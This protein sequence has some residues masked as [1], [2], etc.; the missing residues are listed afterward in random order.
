MTIRWKGTVLAVAL[1]A[2]A[3]GCGG[4]GGGGGGET[5]EPDGGGGSGPLLVDAGGGAGGAQPGGT[6]GSGGDGGAGGTGGAGGQTGGAPT[7]DMGIRFAC[8]DGVDNDDDGLIDLTDPGCTGPEDDD[9]ADTS[10]AAQCS[11]GLDNDADGLP[12]LAD[13]DCSSE[14]DPSEQGDN[15]DTP[16]SNDLDDDGDG[17]VDFPNDPGCRAAGDGDEADGEPAPACANAA[18]DD[19]DGRID[20]PEDPGCQGRGDMNEADPPVAPVCSNGMDDDADGLTDYPADPGCAAAADADESGACGAGHD[21]IDLNAALAADGHY[22]GALEGGSADF[23]GSCG[24]GAGPERIFEYRLPERVGALIFRTDHPETDKP[25]VVY[26][27]S[28]CLDPLDLVCNRGAEANPGTVARLERPEPGL[29]YVVV[30]TSSAALGPGAFRLT[31]ETIPADACDNAR[32]D[33]GDGRIDLADPGC[34]AAD[35]LDEADPLE[36][37]ACANGL[38]DDMDGQTDYPND[39]D[40]AA[41]GTPLEGPLCNPAVNLVEVAAPGGQYNAVLG[42]GDSTTDSRCGPG[43]GIETVFAVSVLEASR[44]SIRA[45]DP[46]EG[47]FQVSVRESCDA[48]ESELDCDLG[49]FGSALSFAYETD[50]AQT[51]YVVVEANQ[52]GFVGPSGQVDVTIEVESLITECND[53]ADNDADGRIDLEDLGCERGSDDSEADP[54]AAPAC[55][56]GLDNDEDGLV[57]FPEDDG[58]IAAGDRREEVS[59]AFVDDLP[60]L[61][62]EGGVVGLQFGDDVYD[63]RCAGSGPDALASFTL[64]TAS[65]V[66]VRTINADFDTVLSVLST[67]EGGGQELACDDDGGDGTMSQLTFARLEPG[68]YFV[69]VEAFGGN[70][71]NADLEVVVVPALPPVCVNELDD[72]GDG[73]VDLA[74]PGCSGPLDEDEADPETP[75]TCANGLDDDGDGQTDYPQDAD[76]AA[77][78]GVT[79]EARCL[80]RRPVVEVGQ[81]G[82]VFDVDLGDNA[83]IASLGCSDGDREVPF[84]LTLTEPSNV[85]VEVVNGAGNQVAVALA[86]RTGC[87]EAAAPDEELACAASFNG[88]LLGRALPPG[89]YYV[90]AEEARFANLGNIRVTI[91]VDSLTRACN[92]GVDNDQDALIDAADPGCERGF[93]DDEA[94]PAAPPA[95]ADGLDNDEDGLVDHP[96]DPDC[97]FA[98]GVVEAARC[99]AGTAAYEVGS[100][101]GE[102]E[103]FF[104]AAR[105][106]VAEDC[107]GEAGVDELIALTVDQ[108]SDVEITA[109]EPG[110]ESEFGIALRTGCPGAGLTLSCM[111]PFGGT[112]IRAPHLA[113]GLY[114]VAVQKRDDSEALSAR[115]RITVTPRVA[116]CNDG[117]DNDEDAL[118]DALDPGCSDALDADE[119]DPELPAACNDDLDN[120]GDGLVDFPEDPE[121]ATAGAGVESLRCPAGT[122]ALEVGAE[123]AA[124]DASFGDAGALGL[125]SC[126]NPDDLFVVSAVTVTETSRIIVDASDDVNFDSLVVAI[127]PD[128]ISTQEIACDSGFGSAGVSTNALEP[129]TYFVLVGASQSFGAL[130]AAVTISVES[131]V[132]ECNDGIDNDE[133]GRFDLNDPGCTAGL[134]DTEADPDVIPACADGIDNDEDGATD[135]PEDSACVAAGG[136]SES[137]SCDLTDVLAILGDDGGRV[138]TD[139]NGQESLYGASCGF[140]ASGGEDVVALVLSAPAS[141]VAEVVAADYDTVVHVRSACDDEATELTCDDDG[142]DAPLAS[143][144]DLPRLEPGVYYIFVD[145]FND[146]GQ[147]TLEVRVTPL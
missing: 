39:P 73:L 116:A 105:D 76:C 27:R 14:A 93:D 10:P 66:T 118:T 102:V 117:V 79:E 2:C 13:P 87:G 85:R 139:T 71:G 122:A 30:D 38:D 5:G 16:C 65:E 112:S 92:D 142:A 26:V 3:S 53:G 84:A 144:V 96:A 60:E 43:L 128:C 114:F 1:S 17:Q 100:A 41:A 95:C 18:D 135:Y 141:V 119:A 50:G 134:D 146:A 55:G 103:L 120:D 147:A 121:C 57:D 51:L 37:P 9:E 24:G 12:D 58:C 123:G 77:A 108:L 67:C 35:D 133:D 44:I 48:I 138:E 21:A 46:A 127:R 64:E 56:D 83:D 28:A 62:P 110:G 34:T 8:N 4:D 132:R 63:N 106:L 32:D 82:G 20:Y 22:D 52:G 69:N 6:G 7:P 88:P 98:G 99:G 75:A 33:D 19:A 47:D 72:D 145:G 129:G 109:V 42:V 137:A 61:G 101:G 54:P 94:D 97:A 49:E 107:F 131:L 104:D 25:T 29:Y 86:L 15:G 23:A 36:V 111:E 113:P 31:V 136:V 126:G 40:C 74:D 81:A 68:T 124:F 80:D 89:L 90:F 45:V 78:G 11:D 130:G 59:C 115:V 70:P 91:T 125:T 140:N 143:L